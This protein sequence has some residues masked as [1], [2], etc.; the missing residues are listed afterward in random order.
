MSIFKL[1]TIGTFA[2]GVVLLAGGALCAVAQTS[3]PPP[4]LALNRLDRDGDQQVSEQEFLAAGEAG[5]AARFAGIDTNHDGALSPREIEVARAASEA[6]LRRL[7]ADDPERAEYAAMPAFDALD[8]DA[9]G[10]VEPSEFAA[11]QQSSLRLRFKRLD[12]NGDGLLTE[13]EFEAA[14]RRFLMQVGHPLESSA[15]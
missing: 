7:A 8:A 13:S 9:S 5:L 2:A 3:A 11:A 14:R 12:E 1:P 4:Y 15:P 10:S 6:R